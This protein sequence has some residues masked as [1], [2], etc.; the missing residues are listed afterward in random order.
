MNDKN[1]K[2]WRNLVRITNVSE[3]QIEVSIPSY[4]ASEI[5]VLSK[6]LFTEDFLNKVT[7]YYKEGK[8]N[9]RFF[10]MVNIGAKTSVD[11]KFEN[12]DNQN[13]FKEM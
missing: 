4:D 9:Y 8:N 6:S 7:E 11:L 10:A 3:S 13:I 2:K 12:C 5:V 1:L